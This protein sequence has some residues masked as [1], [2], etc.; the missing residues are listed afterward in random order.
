MTAWENNPNGLCEDA[1][2]CGCCG[3]Q[4]DG[5]IYDEPD[6]YNDYFD[7]SAIFDDPTCDNCGVITDVWNSKTDDEGQELFFCEDCWVG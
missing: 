2:C 6:D 4:G 1:P 7:S 5:V 3:P